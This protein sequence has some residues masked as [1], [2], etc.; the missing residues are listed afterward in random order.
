MLE[1]ELSCWESGLKI[2]VEDVR[3]VQGQMYAT[4]PGL[5]EGFTYKFRVKAYNVGGPSLPSPPSEPFITAI[6]RSGS[7]LQSFLRSSSLCGG[8]ICTI[9][10]CIVEPYF[11]HPG[12]HDL[13]VKKG[14][15]ICYDLWL[16]GEPAPKIQWYR[17]GQLLANSE[18]T[19]ITQ[20]RREKKAY[21][22]INSCLTI[23]R[24]DRARDKGQYDIV[25]ESRSGKSVA[26]G[27]VNV[28]DVSLAILEVML[29]YLTP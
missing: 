5:T 13:T 27:N 9:V 8:R 19:S 6:N 16:S 21:N 23:E 25:L 26:S 18:V 17:N 4:C 24:S 29:T 15:P 10:L 3:I 11:H 28:L 2:N 20:C 12:M 7:I 14:R 1:K 22:E